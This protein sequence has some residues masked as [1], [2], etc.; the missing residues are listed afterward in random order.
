MIGP[1]GAGKSTLLKLILGKLEP[2]TGTVRRR[3][4]SSRSRISTSCA[5][6]STRERT[7]VETISPGSDWIETASGRKHVMSYLGDFLFPP[8]R[9]NR[10]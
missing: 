7:L 3:H 9:A 1:N 5:R 2:D 10:P 4:A 8:Q 6:S